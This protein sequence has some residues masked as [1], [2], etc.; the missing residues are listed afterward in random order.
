METGD[1]RTWLGCEVDEGERM[2]QKVG[3]EAASM[4]GTKGANSLLDLPA[5]VSPCFAQAFF[6]ISSL[7]QRDRLA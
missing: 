5:E 4:A 7:L 6:R 1:Q 3:A 2:E